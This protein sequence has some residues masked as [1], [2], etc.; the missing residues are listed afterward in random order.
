M[1]AVVTQIPAAMLPH[2]GGGKFMRLFLNQS[3]CFLPRQLS[4]APV[5]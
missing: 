4:H 5:G 2:A 1:L 3:L